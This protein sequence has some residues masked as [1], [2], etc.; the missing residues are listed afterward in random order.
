MKVNWTTLLPLLVTVTATIGTA[1]LTP[2]FL[3]MHPV[4]YAI[5]NAIGMLLHAALP[6]IFGAASSAK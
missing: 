3:M 4:A 6:S 2:V 1:V 5:L